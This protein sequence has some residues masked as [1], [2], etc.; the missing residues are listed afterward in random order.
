MPWHRRRP[1]RNAYA[2]ATV[3]AT[4]VFLVRGVVQL[5]LYQHHATGW[6]AVARIAMGYP[7]FIA[8]IGFG[9]LVVTRARRHVAAADARPPSS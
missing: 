4:F 6:L 5:V 9:F 3:A 2:W 8:A 7:L 1:L